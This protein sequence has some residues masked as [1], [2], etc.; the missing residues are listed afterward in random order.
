MITSQ[1]SQVKKSSQDFCPAATIGAGG[2]ASR[3]PSE[4]PP[5]P[6]GPGAAPRGE[7]CGLHL[8]ERR[9]LW[10][11]ASSLLRAGRGTSKTRSVIHVR[12]R[13]VAVR[14]SCGLNAGEEHSRPLRA[15]MTATALLRSSAF[16]PQAAGSLA[17]RQRRLARAQT[18]RHRRLHRRWPLHRRWHLRL[19]CR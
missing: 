4:A 19:R 17:H 2:A 18:H 14:I 5:L 8:A 10:L 6:H 7:P 13:E 11:P 9:F 12:E 3:A 16:A 15:S 1:S